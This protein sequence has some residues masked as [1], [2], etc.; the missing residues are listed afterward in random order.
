MLEGIVVKGP[1]SEPLKK[2]IINMIGENQENS[3]NYTAMTDAAGRFRL[4]KIEPGRYTVLLEKT[5]YVAVD[6]K[7]H[8]SSSILTVQ[9][10]KDLTDLVF[11]MLPTAVIS[12]RVVDEDGD[13]MAGVQVSA[14]RNSYRSGQ[15]SLEVQA[16][17]GTDDLGEYRLSGLPPG[18][19][20]V[21][22]TPATNY[23][24]LGMK[25][26]SDT[27]DKPDLAYVTTYYP[28]T[29]DKTQAV[30]VQVHP[31]DE[32][33]LSFNLVKINTFRVR[34]FI[35]NPSK[36]NSKGVVVLRSD[37][38]ESV[39]NAAEVEKDGKFELK[40]VAPGSYTAAF[41]TADGGN[42]EVAQTS[43]VVTNAD[44]D[45]L[46][47]ALATPARIQGRVQVEGTFKLDQNEVW[48]SLNRSNG[49]D[50]QASWWPKQEESSVVG[51]DGTFEIKNVF[52]GIYDV[53]VTCASSKGFFAKRITDGG[54]DVAESSLRVSGG[55]NIAVDV[56]LA[57]DGATVDGI[58]TDAQ[59]KP[60]P[61]VTVVAVPDADHRKHLARFVK[62]N[63]DQQ[64]RFVM[65]AIPPGDY[66]LVAWEE[67]EDGAYYDPEVLKKDEGSG[68]R[69]TLTPQSHQSIALKA[70]PAE[71]EHQP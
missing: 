37:D 14:L 13:P 30:A 21:A 46:V 3:N 49:P 20:I 57:S 25:D 63:T 26:T 11:R 2:T 59:N 28:N 16:S 61:N 19:Y 23:R 31:G 4:E 24:S 12:G 38:S 15:R 33:P 17:S 36:T 65:K 60:E 18:K 1:G 50:G 47:L 9:A 56:L 10:G 71:E 42:T 67:I 8:A 68:K 39:F 27:P 64:G 45:N 5:G 40:S 52:P 54:K 48:V 6:A 66:T 43:V 62:A 7:R 53:Q 44:V 35:T 58:V 29:P 70:I 41:E 32:V 69:M 55:A 51:K 22:V 34:G